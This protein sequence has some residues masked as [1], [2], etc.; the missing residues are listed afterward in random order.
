MFTYQGEIEP[1]GVRGQEATVLTTGTGTSAHTPSDVPLR[2][3]DRDSSPPLSKRVSDRQRALSLQMEEEDLER[4]DQWHQREQQQL[5]QNPKPPRA[6]T[7]NSQQKLD[8]HRRRQPDPPQRLHAGPSTFTSASTRYLSIPQQRNLSSNSFNEVVNN[9]MAEIAGQDRSPQQAKNSE[10]K[11]PSPTNQP[12]LSQR[13]MATP[14]AATHPVEEHGHEP[15]TPQ[16]P[17]GQFSALHKQG[18]SAQGEPTQVTPT[19]TMDTASS[20]SPKGSSTFRL[21]A[22]VNVDDSSFEDPLEHI[23]G[24][25]AMAMEHVM[26]GEYDMALQAFTQVL[27]VYL[28]QHGRA[29]PLTASAYHNLGT[30]HTKRAGLLLDH[31]MH[32]RHCREQALL[33]FQAAARSARDCPQLGPNHPNVAVSLVRIGF[34]L[35]QSRQYQNAVI[36]FEEA[37]RIRLDHY[38]PTHGLV[39]NLYNNLGVC[40]MHLQNFSLGR[41]YLQQALDIQKELLNQEDYSTTALLELADTLCNIGGLNLEWIRQQG[42]DARHALDAESAFLEA[43]ELR[44]KVLGEQHPLTNQVRSLHDMVRSIPLPKNAGASKPRDAPSQSYPLEYSPAGVSEMTFGSSAHSRRSTPNHANSNV[45][46]APTRDRDLELPILSKEALTTP[47]RPSVELSPKPSQPRTRI[48]A[49]QARSRS[50]PAPK[51]RTSDYDATEESCLLKRPSDDKRSSGQ[52]G[53]FVVTY[54]QTTAAENEVPSV[55]ESD[56]AATMRQAKAVLEAHRDFME[57]PGRSPGRSPSRYTTINAPTRTNAIDEAKHED[58]ILPLAGDWPAP[59]FERISPEVLQDPIVHLHT[60]HNCAV[61]YMKRGHY[62]EAVDLFEMVVE[63]QKAKNGT[64]HKDVGCALQNVGVA[65]LRKKEYY[66]ALQ[67]FEE[68]VRVRKGALGRDHPDVAVS[69]VKVG[70]S[71][72]LLRRLQDSLWIFREALSVRKLALGS[73]HPSNGR[74]YNNIGCVHVEFNELNEA[75][76]SFEAALDIQRNTLVNDPDNGQVIFGAS[77]TLQ[78]LGYLYTK[79]DMH[80]KAAMVLRE[81][82]SVREEMSK[83]S[84]T[85]L[86][87][88]SFMHSFT[89]TLNALILFCLCSFK[90][91]SCL[92]TTR[93]F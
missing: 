61:S 9:N 5:Q 6:V 21:S 79:R 66:Q 26:R 74:I 40:H 12:G 92:R 42:P 49:E 75:R 86:S 78:N 70:V 15:V 60:I 65:Y 90:K 45:L 64:V 17:D 59:T 38:G 80:E 29:H 31:T 2:S 7:P 19:P 77:T 28:E 22:P 55:P 62:E 37:L 88:Y 44:A 73:L 41:K 46:E 76:R 27:Q 58:G 52:G 63:V 85:T 1:E 25:H 68:A 50:V 67:A 54:A 72:L 87:L 53:S 83:G 16:T 4:A 39:A 93:R 84:L 13:A 36:T 57:S 11:M 89:S 3:F 82:L 47:E 81:S 18:M 32:Q 24:I 33:C 91:E 10:R 69:L 8:Q 20:S 23:Q 56:R 51:T 14:M 34:L 48:P 35:L 71:L 43:L 30:V